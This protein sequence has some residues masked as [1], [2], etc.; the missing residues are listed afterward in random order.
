MTLTLT[1]FDARGRAE[2]IRLLLAYAGVAFE[3]RGL[4]FEQFLKHKAETPLGQLPYLVEQK[5]GASVTIPQSM[6]IVRHLAR[7]HGLDGKTEPERVAADVASETA[8]DMVGALTRLRFS[9]AWQDES[10]K[11]K[12][13]AEVVPQHLGRLDKLLGDRTW[14]AAEKPTYAD[15]V[16]FDA[17]DRHV[18]N[19]PSI[20]EGHPRLA[21]FKERVAALPELAKYLATRRPA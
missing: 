8:V 10:L 19:W 15:L 18:I 1:Y 16:V 4:S 7:E 13:A 12:H 6:A 14:F 9:P 5:D 3:D 20:L 21:A 17:L 2:P 11:A